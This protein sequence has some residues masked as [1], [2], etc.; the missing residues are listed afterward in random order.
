MAKSQKST[1]FIGS[2]FGLCAILFS[3]LYYFK[4]VKNL[5]L[6]MT[7]IYVMYFVGMAFFF[8]GMYLKNKQVKFWWISYT[9]GII[10]PLA[11]TGMLIYGFS[12]GMLEWF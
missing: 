3:L 1:I 9:L 6:Y 7:A 8:N 12:T 10:L 4:L 2:L 5:D 11:S